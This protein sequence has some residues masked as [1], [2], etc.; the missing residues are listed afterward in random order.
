MSSA[1]PAPPSTVKRSS[2]LH[3]A[4]TARSTRSILD[5]AARLHATAVRVAAL[6]QDNH[7]EEAEEEY[8]DDEEEDEQVLAGAAGA[9]AK[10]GKGGKSGAGGGKRRGRG[11]GEVSSADGAGRSGKRKASRVSLLDLVEKLGMSEEG[12]VEPNYVTTTSSP[13]DHPPRSFCSVCG[14]LSCYTC[15]RCGMRYCSIPCQ[16]THNDTTCIKFGT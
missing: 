2:R 13:P 5:R 4:S 8:K 16:R 6:E 11:G 14:Y 15:V 1:P 9:K 12:T 7:V 10:G 3:A